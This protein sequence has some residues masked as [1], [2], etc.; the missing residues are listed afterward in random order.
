MRT[1]THTRV[2]T[3]AYTHTS[4]LLV[5]FFQPGT[6]LLSL[7]VPNRMFCFLGHCWMDL[8]H[9][10]S[11]VIS[12]LLRFCFYLGMLILEGNPK[13]KV[14]AEINAMQTKD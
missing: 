8:C 12:A 2:H 4:V 5:V 9:G 1:H 11:T 3:H 6:L 7:P 14:T 13:Q 10:T